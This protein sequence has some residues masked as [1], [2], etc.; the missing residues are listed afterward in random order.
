MN[1]VKLDDHHLDAKSSVQVFTL[2]I[3]LV[4]PDGALLRDAMVREMTGV[5]EEILASKGKVTPRLNRVIANC[6]IEI[7]GQ[8]A[9]LAM[10]KGL[11]MLD[12]MFLL[13]AIRRVSLGDSYEVKL[14]CPNTACLTDGTY[15]IDLGGLATTTPED[16]R[17][18]QHVLTTPSGTR[19]DWHTMNGEDE[20]WLEAMR[21]KLNGEGLPTL[22]MLARIDAIDGEPLPRDNG[23]D[24]K[25]SLSRLVSLSLRDR[26][27]FRHAHATSEGDMD[28]EVE[29]ACATCGFEFKAEMEVAAAGFFF[30]SGV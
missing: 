14:K 9:T 24:V 26:N 10:V 12:R 13:I 3:G 30:P 29:F 15:R 5:E 21:A 18:R 27:A 17:Q 19:I 6:L 25:R 23:P 20:E 2:P 11:T 7:G 22:A 1:D 4:M 16:P 8:K 28:T